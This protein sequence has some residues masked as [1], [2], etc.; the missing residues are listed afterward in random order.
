VWAD[1]GPQAYPQY[2][3]WLLSW[4]AVIGNGQG[5][6]L[7]LSQLDQAIASDHNLVFVGVP[8]G[9]V[10]GG[11]ALPISWDADGVSL[12]GQSFPGAAL[13]FVYPAGEQL[14]GYFS[15]PAGSEQL[16]FRYV[17]FSSRAG[18]ADDLLWSADGLLATGF[19][20]ADWAIEPSFASGL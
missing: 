4:W 3:A 7:P 11:G 12:G 2:A 6:G 8:V 5:C 9:E 20:D 17:P 16:L 15:A 13:A 18:Y 1:D 19:F 14:R 10:P